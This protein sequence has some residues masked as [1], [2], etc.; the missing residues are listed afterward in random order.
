MFLLQLYARTRERSQ[1]EKGTVD[2]VYLERQRQRMTSMWQAADMYAYDIAPGFTLLVLSSPPEDRVT[3]KD[4]Q[5]LI[6]KQFQPYVDALTDTDTSTDGPSLS[7]LSEF[8]LCK[9][10][11]NCQWRI[12]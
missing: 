5:D 6:M 11:T 1:M 12:V 2:T 4:C 10:I 8:L 3:A 7:Q 9:G